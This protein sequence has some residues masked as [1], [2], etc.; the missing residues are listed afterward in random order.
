M[1]ATGS[2][3]Q[4]GFPFAFGSPARQMSLAIC[5]GRHHQRIGTNQAPTDQPVPHRSLPLAS[6]AA[7]EYARWNQTRNTIAATRIE[8]VKMPLIRTSESLAVSASLSEGPSLV[9]AALTW[10]EYWSPA[11][12]RATLITPQRTRTPT[13]GQAAE[14]RVRGGRWT[15]VPSPGAEGPDPVGA[16][17]TVHRFPSQ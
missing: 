12:S 10:S 14:T 6:P 3:F 15:A 5:F 1:P 13:V 4:S 2:E 9:S 11:A 8:N 16:S 7:F 17:S